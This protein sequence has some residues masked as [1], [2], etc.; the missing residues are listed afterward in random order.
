MNVSYYTIEEEEKKNRGIIFRSLFKSKNL[1]GAKES[2]SLVKRITMRMARRTKLYLG[3][4]SLIN[5]TAHAADD[6]TN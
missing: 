3:L 6:V 1:H 5:K 4:G 2:S